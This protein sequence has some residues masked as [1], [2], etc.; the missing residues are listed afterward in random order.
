MN[1]W[2]LQCQYEDVGH[3]VRME[4]VMV[5]ARPGACALDV[6]ANPSKNGDTHPE[7]HVSFRGSEIGAGWM[8]LGEASVRIISV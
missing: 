5:V 4:F 2:R 3:A 1:S 7:F 8:R 6:L